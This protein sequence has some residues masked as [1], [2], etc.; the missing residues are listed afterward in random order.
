MS[1]LG[2]AVLVWWAG[3][4]DCICMSIFGT[5]SFLYD[6]NGWGE[7]ICDDK[8]QIAEIFVSNELKIVWNCNQP[9]AALMI[10]PSTKACM[11]YADSLY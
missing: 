8:N 2:H 7:T 4:Q 6:M 3:G 5:N 10:L 9:E 1:F 11:I